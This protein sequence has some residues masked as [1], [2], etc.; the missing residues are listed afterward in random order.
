MVAWEKCSMNKEKAIP[1]VIVDDHP[2]F[3]S[4]LRAL[5]EAYPDIE[6]IG[7]AR[8]GLEA[9]FLVE[10]FRPSVVVMDINM[11]KM[12]G[13]EATAQITKDFPE[14]SIIGLSVDAAA[15]NQEAIKQ[16]GAVLLLSKE[17]AGE[18]LYEAIRKTMNNREPAKQ[19]GC[20]S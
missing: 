5:L 9:I 3:R 20:Y 7:E 19:P 1:V 14:T 10:K 11:P 6:V 16:A 17:A 8:N 12:N 2:I 13:I 15:V 18:E 4:G